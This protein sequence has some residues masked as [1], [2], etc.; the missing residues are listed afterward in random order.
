MPRYHLSFD[1]ENTRGTRSS[2]D[3]VVI[4]DDMDEAAR[5]I[6]RERNVKLLHV[7]KRHFYG[8]PASESEI[9][10]RVFEVG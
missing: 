1:Y 2:G 8:R 5:R 4:A 10:D 3:Q 9:I 7:S 6:A